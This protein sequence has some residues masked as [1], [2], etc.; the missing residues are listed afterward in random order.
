M[1]SIGA[2]AAASTVKGMVAGEA[3]GRMSTTSA[4]PQ[5]QAREFV[6]ETD[7]D[8]LFGKPTTGEGFEQLVASFSSRKQGHEQEW[9]IARSGVV[10]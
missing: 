6:G 9:R 7:H 10:G 5:N 4:A 1:E 8:A 2:N 3:K